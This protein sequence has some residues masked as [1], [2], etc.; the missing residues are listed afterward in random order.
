MDQPPRGLAMQQPVPRISHADP[1]LSN[2]LAGGGM[3]NQMM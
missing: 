1:P 2:N 3:G